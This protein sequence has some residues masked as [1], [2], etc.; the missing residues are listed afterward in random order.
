MNQLSKIAKKETIES[1]L[2]TGTVRGRYFEELDARLIAM[3]LLPLGTPTDQTPMFLQSPA[4]PQTLQYGMTQPPAAAKTYAMT[5]LLSTPDLARR[6]ITQ[7]LPD[8]R[9]QNPYAT[10]R[11]TTVDE[12]SN[13][14]HFFP[15]DQDAAWD[16]YNPTLDDSSNNEGPRA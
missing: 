4:R 15:R 3:G 2:R 6:D 7:A 8:Q 11:S 1:P 14:V 13:V 16:G 9:P 5:A 12:S 10:K